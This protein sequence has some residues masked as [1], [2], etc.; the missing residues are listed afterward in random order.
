MFFNRWINGILRKH[1]KE[2]NLSEYLNEPVLLETVNQIQY[3]RK[4]YEEYYSDNQV[5]VNAGS[6]ITKYI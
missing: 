1:N 5:H 3:N 4:R 6:R 2:I